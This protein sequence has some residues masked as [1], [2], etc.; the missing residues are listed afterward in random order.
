MGLSITLKLHQNVKG[1]QVAVFHCTTPEFKESQSFRVYVKMTDYS[2]Q[3]FARIK[4][5]KFASVIG[6]SNGVTGKQMRIYINLKSGVG[7]GAP[8]G[9]VLRPM[10]FI[11]S[12]LP[13]SLFNVT[14]VRSFPHGYL[15]RILET[16]TGVYVGKAKVNKTRRLY[17]K[18]GDK[19]L[20]VAFM[21]IGP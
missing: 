4:P 11:H 21:I 17:F 6:T 14:E 19:V 5:R 1:E 16:K 12:L 20:S 3:R 18:K 10:I 9:L 13:A 7:T 2:G 8:V 15:V